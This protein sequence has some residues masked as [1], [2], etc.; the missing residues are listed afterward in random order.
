MSRVFANGLED[1][2][3]IPAQIIQKTQKNGT[4]C[5]FA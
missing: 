3:S 5:C 1:Q 2:G 4:W